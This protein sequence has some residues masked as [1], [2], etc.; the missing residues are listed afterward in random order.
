MPV[1]D[2]SRRPTG[3]GAVNGKPAPTDLW[4]RFTVAVE[5]HNLMYCFL[6]VMIGKT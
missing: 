6:G 3:R 1:L 2:G 5:R 4:Y